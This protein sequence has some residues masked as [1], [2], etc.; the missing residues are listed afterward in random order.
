MYYFSV[1]RP[2]HLRSNL[3][4]SYTMMLSKWQ[5]KNQS[6]RPPESCNR[7]IKLVI[8]TELWGGIMITRQKKN[9][10]SWLLLL[11]MRQRLLVNC[12]NCIFQRFVALMELMLCCGNI[13]VVTEYLLRYKLALRFISIYALP[14]FLLR[15]LL[16]VPDFTNGS[17]R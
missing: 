13:L 1:L 7:S 15:G 10:I 14:L 16:F 5:S 4:R 17:G 6:N 8:S 2:I 9:V 11:R 12:H 3:V